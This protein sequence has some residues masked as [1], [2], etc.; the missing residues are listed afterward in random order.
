M[1]MGVEAVALEGKAKLFRLLAA[2][3]RFNKAV[4]YCQG[5]ICFVGLWKIVTGYILHVCT[6]VL[7]I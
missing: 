7:Q 3:S 2:Y 1:F 6:H 4:E 5:D